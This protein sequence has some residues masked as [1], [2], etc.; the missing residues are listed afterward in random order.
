MG[1][2]PGKGTQ[3]WIERRC[4]FCCAAVQPLKIRIFMGNA[5]NVNRLP[6]KTRR[7]DATGN[8]S[9][10]GRWAA[11]AAG[12]EA[13]RRGIKGPEPAECADSENHPFS[14]PPKNKKARFGTGVPVGP[15]PDPAQSI[16]LL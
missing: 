4:K 16:V 13:G 8:V 15:N 3:K 6:L 14:V 5:F 10:T 1:E 7:M 9:F 12:G 2:K 11:M